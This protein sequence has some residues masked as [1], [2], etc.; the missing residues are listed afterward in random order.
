[1]FAFVE[2]VVL[3]INGKERLRSGNVEP[4]SETWRNQSNMHI[5]QGRRSQYSSTSFPSTGIYLEN[6]CS[7][8][9]QKP[10]AFGGKGGMQVLLGCVTGYLEK[11]TSLWLAQYAM[12][13]LLCHWLWLKSEVVE[14]YLVQPGF[15]HGLFPRALSHCSEYGELE[16][17]F[18]KSHNPSQ[19]HPMPNR[20]DLS[21]DRTSKTNARAETN[22]PQA[23]IISRNSTHSSKAGWPQAA[24]TLIFIHP[25][26]GLPTN[27]DL[28][29]VFTAHALHFHRSTCLT[30]SRAPL[31]W[32]KGVGDPIPSCQY[33]RGEADLIGVE[34]IELN[35]GKG[36]PSLGRYWRRVKMAWNVGRLCPMWV[37]GG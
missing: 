26:G 16:N 30:S 22:N 4:D 9:L 12:P 32:L 19:L 2:E 13:R 36:V 3:K 27:F 20:L 18:P 35:V 34:K 1:M 31:F 33:Q 8:T 37:F 25:D 28:C 14:G 29:N 7:I 23:L 24:S 11:W 5:H 6:G 17:N 21:S 10:V 15:T